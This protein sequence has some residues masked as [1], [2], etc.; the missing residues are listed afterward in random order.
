M[1]S[2]GPCDTEDG[3]VT[4]VFITGINHISKQIKIFFFFNCNIISQYYCFHCTF[5]QNKLASKRDFQKQI[6]DSKLLN[7]SVN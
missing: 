4:E 5:D 1:I 2:E 7:S 6:I 3:D